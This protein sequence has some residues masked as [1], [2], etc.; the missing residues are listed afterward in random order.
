MNPGGST[1][2]TTVVRMRS[3]ARRRLPIASAVVIA[4]G[5]A[6]VAAALGGDAR[7]QVNITS[8]TTTT[9]PKPDKAGV[10]HLHFEYGPIEIRPGQNIIDTNTYAIPQPP[11]RRLDRRLQA[12]PA[13]GQRQGAG[14]RRDPPA[15]RRVG[16]RD[17]LAIATAPLFPERFIAAGEEKTALDLPPGYGYRYRV[18]RRL[19]PQLHDPRPHAEAVHGVDHLRRRLRACDVTARG[20]R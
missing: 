6:L 7:A 13:I 12:E 15:P 9:V 4:L 20:R 10:Q 11:G 19:V 16:E 17:A 14:G 8:D 2:V 18:E 1:A 5:A 3:P